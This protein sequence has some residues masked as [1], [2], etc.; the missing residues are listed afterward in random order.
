MVKVELR[1]AC[2]SSPQNARKKQHSPLL[3][4]CPKFQLSADLGRSGQHVFPV[5]GLIMGDTLPDAI[6]RVEHFLRGED[7]N[8]AQR[9][10]AQR[11][12]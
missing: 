7:P 2:L 4:G 10:T 12:P 3:G 9:H 11:L 6:G 5:R 8:V 1:S